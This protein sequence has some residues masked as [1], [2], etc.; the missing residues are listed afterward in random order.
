MYSLENRR[1]CIVTCNRMDHSGVLICIKCFEV[2]LFLY[3]LITNPKSATG[4]SGPSSHVYKIYTVSE[5]QGLETDKGQDNQIS[6][7]TDVNRGGPG[8]WNHQL[9]RERQVGIESLWKW[10]G[11]YM[12][13]EQQTWQYRTDCDQT[14]QTAKTIDTT[15]QSETTHNKLLEE[16]FQTQLQEGHSQVSCFRVGALQNSGPPGAKFVT[17]AR[18]NVRISSQDLDGIIILRLVLSELQMIWSYQLIVV[19]SLY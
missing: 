2:W 4:V 10:S 12:V 19:V 9:G 13:L 5:Y 1:C 15:Q 18:T 8:K 14:D 7:R 16:M 6:G 17:C 3:L 11:L